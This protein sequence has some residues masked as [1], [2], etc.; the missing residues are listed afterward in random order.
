[1][2]EQAVDPEALRDAASRMRALGGRL[3][4]ARDA[5]RGS[6]LS[7]QQA[8]GELAPRMAEVWRIA[9]RAVDHLQQDYQHIEQLLGLLAEHYP[10]LDRQSIGR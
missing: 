6:V 10:A 9:E 5:A 4:S 8:C 3:G 7:R 1:M 2:A